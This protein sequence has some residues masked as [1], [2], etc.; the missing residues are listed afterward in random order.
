[1]NT[2]SFYK[3]G[4]HKHGNIS[5][6]AAGCTCFYRIK[7]K[8]PD[9]SVE[10]ALFFPLFIKRWFQSFDLHTLC[11]TN[12]FVCNFLSSSAGFNLCSCFFPAHPCLPL[13]LLTFPRSLRPDLSCLPSRFR[14][15]A[16]CLFPFALPRFASHSCSTSASLMLS[17][18]GFSASLPVPFVPFF[19]AS[20]Y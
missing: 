1:M 8:S 16:S 5:G 12:R 13:S 11:L 17:L 2:G 14:Y 19:S 4:P 7:Q 18:S 6:F 15:S 20:G 9:F 10:T 3:D